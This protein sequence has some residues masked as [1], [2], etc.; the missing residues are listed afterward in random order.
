[1]RLLN[2][3]GLPPS[4]KRARDGRLLLW[5]GRNAKSRRQSRSG[6]LHLDRARDSLGQAGVSV[7][8]ST[9]C[10]RTHRNAHSKT[11]EQTLDS[12]FCQKQQKLPQQR[13]AAASTVIN[14]I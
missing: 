10:E 6:A 13:S 11:P 3:R 1:M 4:S 7:R 9:E 14:L 5:R 2:H 12:A 8:G